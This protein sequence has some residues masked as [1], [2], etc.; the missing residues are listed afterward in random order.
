MIFQ[1]QPRDTNHYILEVH[2]HEEKDKSF[3]TWDFKKATHF[4]VVMRPIDSDDRY[5]DEVDGEFLK[6]L[7]ENSNLSLSTEFQLNNKTSVELVDYKHYM[8]ENRWY[9]SPRPMKAVVFSC[10]VQNNVCVVYVPNPISMS[11]VIVP[12][13]LTITK[14][15]KNIEE[16]P[17]F[18]LFKHKNV[19]ELQFDE[20][21]VKLSA[22]NSYTGGIYYTVSNVKYNFPVTDMMTG[23]AF[24][25][26][27]PHGSEIKFFVDAKSEKNYSLSEK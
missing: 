12:E 27:V 5:F 21:T 6:D 25:L 9:Y 19:D 14:I 3:L 2:E 16:K 7:N 4:L 13:K 20:Y 1:L 24:S 22:L 26:T 8:R 18:R 17:K 11:S 10:D 23:K 15:K